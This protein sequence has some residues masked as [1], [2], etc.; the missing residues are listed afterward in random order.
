M[1]VRTPPP[2]LVVPAHT[3]GRPPDGELQRAC[4]LPACAI[5]CSVRIE[6]DARADEQQKSGKDELPPV[7]SLVRTKSVVF[8]TDMEAPATKLAAAVK[9]DLSAK[10]QIRANVEA[11]EEEALAAVGLDRPLAS[12]LVPGCGLDPCVELDIAG[13][14]KPVGDVFDIGKDFRLGRIAFGPFPFLLKLFG[15]L[16][17]ILHAFDVAARTGIAVPV[18]RAADARC[19]IDE[20]RRKAFLAE[21]MQ[22]VE[23]GET[24][25]HDHRVEPVARQDFSFLFVSHALCPEYAVKRSNIP[26]YKYSG[27]AGDDKPLP[28]MAPG[29][30]VGK[31][32]CPSLE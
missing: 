10:Q 12:I 1:L 31:N 32:P 19:R 15:E 25:P 5:S 20:T 8:G 4:A 29:D 9:N 24:G 18:P 11:F 7:K 14:V 3:G 30:F 2:V 21:Y 23:T 28:R 22:H 6:F 16:E 17:G 27:V 13:Q 26:I